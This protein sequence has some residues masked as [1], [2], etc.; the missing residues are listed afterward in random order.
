MLVAS[1]RCEMKKIGSAKK[2]KHDANRYIF[3]PV[4]L[5]DEVKWREPIKPHVW[6]AMLK[7]ILERK[8]EEV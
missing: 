1:R 6:R 2:A 7:V 5:T 4:I 3:S 8:C